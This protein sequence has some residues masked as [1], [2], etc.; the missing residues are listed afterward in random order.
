MSVRVRDV[1]SFCCHG[2]K[3]NPRG[4]SN[5]F[6]QNFFSQQHTV[7]GNERRL[8]ST[9]YGQIRRGVYYLIDESEE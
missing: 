6:T 3:Y 4:R 8:L 5:R 1:V 2:L 7:M 9:L